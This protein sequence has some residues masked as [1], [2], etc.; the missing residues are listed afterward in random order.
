MTNTISKEIEERL[1]IMMQLEDLSIVVDLRTNNGFKGRKFDAF[2]DKM[3]AY[4]N[5]VCVLQFVYHQYF[6]QINC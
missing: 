4:F 5:E 1:R 3:E 2:W 6:I